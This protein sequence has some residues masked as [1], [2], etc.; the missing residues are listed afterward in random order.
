MNRKSL[1]SSIAFRGVPN[2]HIAGVICLVLCHAVAAESPSPAELLDRYAANQDRLK[3]FIVKIEST[4]TH[5]TQNGSERQSSSKQNI[6]ELRYEDNGGDIRVYYSVREVN[7]QTDGSLVPADQCY[8]FLWDRKRYYQYFWA[9]ALVDRDIFV[10]AK[11][12]MIKYGIACEIAGSTLG[13]LSGDQ[14]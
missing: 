10:S 6:T 3:S 4:T 13:I 9:P 8:S 2:R 7:R 14:D 12:E 11:K 1:S 5:L